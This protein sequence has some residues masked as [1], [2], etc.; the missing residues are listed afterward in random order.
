MIAK[1][2]N[3]QWSNKI[4]CLGVN[5]DESV[6]VNFILTEGDEEIKR[7]N[8]FSIPATSPDYALLNLTEAE[9]EEL[10]NPVIEL[11]E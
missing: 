5:E 6:S 7:E 2:V 9:I 4:E 11:S 8:G 10:K 3:I 1:I